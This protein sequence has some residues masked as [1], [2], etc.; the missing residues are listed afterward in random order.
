MATGHSVKSN[1]ASH[2]LFASSSFKR[3]TNFCRRKGLKPKLEISGLVVREK[4]G[5]TY[6]PSLVMTL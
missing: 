1:M 4:G 3:S 6:N 2:R 5:T